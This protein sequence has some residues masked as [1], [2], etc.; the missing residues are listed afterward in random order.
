MLI[1]FEHAPYISDINLRAEV[2]D[3]ERKY[4]KNKTDVTTAWYWYANAEIRRNYRREEPVTA[5]ILEFERRYPRDERLPTLYQLGMNY[6]RDLPGEKKLRDM[7]A[8]KYP[9]SQVAQ[10]AQRLAK[11][12]AVEGKEF[13]MS[14]EDQLTGRQIS[15]RDLRGKIVVIDFWAT[16]CGP[17]ISE[18]PRMKQI[19]DQ[20]K[21]V[22][23]EFIGISLDKDPEVLKKFCTEN[24]VTWPQYCERDKAWDTELSSSWGISSIP[25]IFILDKNGRVYSAFARGKLER[26]IPELLRS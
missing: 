3:Y 9:D 20:Y 5:V 14:F 15:T 26:L 12:E 11:L 13:D 17:C 2:E 25:T 1:R 21:T 23:V 8:E 19:Y 16:W 10:N 18:L 6:L 22:G 7:V 24:D 4:Q